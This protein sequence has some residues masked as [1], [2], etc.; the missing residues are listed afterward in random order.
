MAFGGTNWGNL[1]FPG[2]YTSY[3]YGA[4]VMENRQ[5]YREK[6]SEMKLIGNFLKV[7]P[8]MLTGSVGSLNNTISSTPEILVNPLYGNGT[9]TNFYL[10]RQT[11]ETLIKS[12]PY[13]VSLSTSKGFL[14]IPQLGGSLTLSGRDAK[15]HVTDY[16]VGSFTL[17]YST[18]EIFTWKQVDGKT[19]LVVY[20]GA[21]EQHELSVITLS[22]IKIL[23]GSEVIS[24]TV[25]GTAVLGWETSNTRRVVQIG[26]LFVYLLDR[27][28]AYNYWVPDFKRNDEW[29]S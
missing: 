3:D 28:T 2:G 12:S 20:G 25:N 6:Y 5:I 16:P 9:G 29:A 17:L 14:A 22:P 7:S 8:A 21:G 13:T 4:A 23:E 26:N 1:G 27:N 11:D 18:A 15:W 10:I 19:F 24:K